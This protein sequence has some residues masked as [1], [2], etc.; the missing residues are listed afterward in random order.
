MV[1]P[2]FRQRAGI[3]LAAEAVALAGAIKGSA[4]LQEFGFL[5]A[6]TM[7]AGLT[8]VLHLMPD[9][10]GDVAERLVPF[11]LALGISIAGI[12]GRTATA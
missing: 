2:P 3:G 5:S 1:A 12:R 4:T 10:P 8:V 7:G 9:A 11:V 6:M